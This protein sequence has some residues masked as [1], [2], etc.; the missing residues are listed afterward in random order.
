MSTLCKGKVVR[1]NHVWH[2]LDC[3]CIS[4]S[5]DTQHQP[6]QTRAAHF[7]SCLIE[8]AKEADGQE[9]VEAATAAL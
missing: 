7:V 4:T 2:C 6:M 8:L 3:G 9:K 5:W 1:E